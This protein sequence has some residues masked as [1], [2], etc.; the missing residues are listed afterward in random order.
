MRKFNFFDSFFNKSKTKTENFDQNLKFHDEIA[1]N[2]NFHPQIA[3]FF[4]S[5]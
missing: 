4:P 1:K 2:K 3:I 5:S